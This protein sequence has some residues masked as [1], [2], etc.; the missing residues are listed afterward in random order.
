MSDFKKRCQIAEDCLPKSDF[1]N[2]M[3]KLHEEMN[4]RITELEFFKENRTCMGCWGEKNHCGCGAA[5][6]C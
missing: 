6:K 4:A 3:V 2:L 5:D 1:K